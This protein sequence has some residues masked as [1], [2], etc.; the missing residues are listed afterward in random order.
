MV[1]LSGTGG[2]PESE[3]ALL[4]RLAE[5]RAELD[6]REAELDMRMA[7]V[8][9]A[10]KRIEE[11]TA[12]LAA[13]EV[14]INAMVEEKRTLEEAQF[15]AVVAMYE[16]MKPKDAAA[17]FDQLDM[18]VLLRVSRAMNPR[19]MAPIMAKMNPGRAQALTAAMAVDRVE[20]TIEVGSQDLDALPQIIGE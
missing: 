19:K 5:R 8:E 11:R 10:E 3:T 16:T 2:Q 13:L 7:L 18:Q 17:I 14:R 15:V 6:A 9:A 1:T 20:P 12:A 4:G